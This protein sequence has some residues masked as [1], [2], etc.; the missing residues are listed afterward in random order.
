MSVTL[1]SRISMRFLAWMSRSVNQT[2]CLKSQVWTRK[3]TQQQTFDMLPKAWRWRGFSGQHACV[4]VCVCKEGWQVDNCACHDAH[5]IMGIASG[6]HIPRAT[7]CYASM[8][9]YISSN[10]LLNEGNWSLSK[11]RRSGLWPGCEHTHMHKYTHKQTRL[12]FHFIL[13]RLRVTEVVHYDKIADKA[14]SLPSIMMY[15]NSKPL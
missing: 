13:L 8:T 9:P 3:T 6:Q 12:P 5:S 11:L 14:P 10:R 15:L 7:L 2:L 1:S 4:C